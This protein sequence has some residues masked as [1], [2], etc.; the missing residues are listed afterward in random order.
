MR[1]A[2]SLFVTKQPPEWVAPL[3]QA[4]LLRSFELAL[5]PLLGST[6]AAHCRVAGWDGNQLTLWADSAIWAT[7]VRY[8][9]PYYIENLAKNSRLPRVAQVQIKVRPPQLVVAKPLPGPKRYAFHTA[10]TMQEA[11]REINDP[12]L[13][14]ALERLSR[15]LAGDKGD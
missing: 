13:R 15:R 2:Y 7:K 3:K 5:Q 6:L 12:G 1:Q 4:Q 14:S 8:N 10:M 9:S 11:A